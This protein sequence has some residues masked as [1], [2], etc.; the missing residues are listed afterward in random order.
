MPDQ[1]Y[2]KIS[3]LA[4][5]EV[6]ARH[7]TLNEFL[8]LTTTLPVDRDALIRVAQSNT[9]I[10]R[11]SLLMVDL[12]GEP[13]VSWH[14]Q[15]SNQ[16]FNDVALLLGNST[17]RKVHVNWQRGRLA[18]LLTVGLCHQI[19]LDEA[20]RGRLEI[21]A[22]LLEVGH[23]EL[24]VIGVEAI[25]RSELLEAERRRSGQTGAEAGAEWL[26]QRGLSTADCDVLRF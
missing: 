7:Q 15:V 25:P 16:A 3:T 22:G 13:L 8:K 18:Q 23:Q 12:S 4:G 21:L 6:P 24:D 20:E 9:E 10:L 1:A 5:P 11:Q 26:A 19:G 2:R 17:Q 14:E